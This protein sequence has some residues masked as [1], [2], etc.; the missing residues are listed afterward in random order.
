[1]LKKKLLMQKIILYK[2]PKMQNS[3]SKIRRIRLKDILR[4]KLKILKI[5]S[6]KRL[7]KQRKNLAKR[8]RIL[9]QEKKISNNM[10]VKN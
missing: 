4:E 10:P 3:L 8:L 6:N 2:K 1:M 7:N 9:L 5:S